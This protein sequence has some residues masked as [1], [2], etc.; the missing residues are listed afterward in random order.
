MKSLQ[1]AAPYLFV[2]FGDHAS[3]LQVFSEQAQLIE[4]TFRIL[5]SKESLLG[6][7]DAVEF[8]FSSLDLDQEKRVTIKVMPSSQ[9]SEIF[10]FEVYLDAYC[11]FSTRT[12]F[13]PTSLKAFV[14]TEK[15]SLE[16]HF[17]MDDPALPSS[18]VYAMPN[19]LRGFDMSHITHETLTAIFELLN[20]T[21]RISFNE[22]REHQ[23]ECKKLAN[24]VK[25]LHLG[26]PTLTP[27]IP[28]NPSI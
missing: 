22:Q 5:F 2:A 9:K 24:S 28:P 17:F 25:L 1:F 14:V 11:N 19:F 10:H 12:G 23:K 4:E 7:N 15:Y 13:T 27:V 3:K 6:Q 21:M 20:E 16:D 26:V 8:Q 18:K